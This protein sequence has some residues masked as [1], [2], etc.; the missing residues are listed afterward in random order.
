MSVHYGLENRKVRS[1]FKTGELFGNKFGEN[2]TGGNFKNFSQT[3]KLDY[4]GSW[5]VS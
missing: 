1:F 5:L 2:K 4:P 3:E